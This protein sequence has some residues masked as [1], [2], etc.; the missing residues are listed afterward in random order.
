M[1]TTI[2]EQRFTVKREVVLSE[3]EIDA[4]RDEALALV[5]RRLDAETEKKA[6][7]SL[8]KK[9]IDGISAHI[10]TKMRAIETGKEEREITVWWERMEDG[11]G[12]M[13]VDSAGRVYERRPLDEHEKQRS[14]FDVIGAKANKPADVEPGDAEDN[15]AEVIDDSGEAGD[16]HE[17]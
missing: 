17:G 4:Y 7:S 10:E 13:L 15:D 14:I 8:A 3:E 16:A 5:K 1:T 2:L 6:A 12:A 11:E 9:R